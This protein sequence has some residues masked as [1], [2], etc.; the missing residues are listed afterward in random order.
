MKIPS[1]A[2]RNQDSVGRESSDDQSAEYS[3]AK[4]RPEDTA[5]ALARKSA[6]ETRQAPVLQ[7]RLKESR[8]IFET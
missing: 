4:A 3:E 2:S 8:F 7:T 1:F 5:K 6:H